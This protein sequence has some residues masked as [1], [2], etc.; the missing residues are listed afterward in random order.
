MEYYS[1]IKRMR[2]ILPFRTTWMDLESVILS[3]IGQIE[4]DKYCMNPLYVEYFLR[5]INKHN[6]TEIESQ[7]Q[8]NKQVT[9]R[10]RGVQDVRE[11][12]KEDKEIQISN[13]KINE[14]W[15]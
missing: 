12:V 13:Y 3:K 6:K 2:E 1:V 5:Q 8:K 14:S 7:V 11:I 15:I 4:K 10:G 9:I